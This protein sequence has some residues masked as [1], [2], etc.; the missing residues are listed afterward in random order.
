EGGQ[1]GYI[2]AT[3]FVVRR[4]NGRGASRLSPLVIDS[5]C[6]YQ[7]SVGNGVRTLGYQ[8]ETDSI[9]SNDVT[10]FR[11]IC[12]AGTTSRPGPMRRSR[13]R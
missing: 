10:I 2:S 1:S 7:T 11:R 9:H 8:F 13:D 3:D 6:F 12:S 4:Q 5:V